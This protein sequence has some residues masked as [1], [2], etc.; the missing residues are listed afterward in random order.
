MGQVSSIL[1]RH[2]RDCSQ[3][4]KPTLKVTP[5]HCLPHQLSPQAEALDCLNPL[6]GGEPLTALDNQAEGQLAD[7]ARGSWKNRAGPLCGLW[8]QRMSTL[9]T[10][11]SLG[12]GANAK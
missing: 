9:M 10:S 4:S 7:I 8:A 3:L 1:L 11:S 2:V 6:E 5:T 12:K